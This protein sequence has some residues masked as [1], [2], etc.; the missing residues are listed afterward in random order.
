MDRKSEL[1]ARVS[2][3]EGLLLFKFSGGT[4]FLGTGS[5]TLRAAPLLLHCNGLR[6][7]VPYRSFPSVQ[8][9]HFVEN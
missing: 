6:S 1:S 5:P 7:V 8:R 2:V 9:R 4:P 3:G